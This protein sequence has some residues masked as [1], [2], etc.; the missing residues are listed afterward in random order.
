MKST[1][2]GNT[3]KACFLSR[4]FQQHLKPYLRVPQKWGTCCSLHI[5]PIPSHARSLKRQYPR[6]FPLFLWSISCQIFV[7][8][9]NTVESWALHLHQAFTAKQDGACLLRTHILGKIHSHHMRSTAQ[10]GQRRRQEIF[11]KQGNSFV[12]WDHESHWS[13][14]LDTRP[15]RSVEGTC[16]MDHLSDTQYALRRSQRASEQA[17][18][19]HFDV[20]EQWKL[21]RKRIKE[22]IWSWRDFPQC[23]MPLCAVN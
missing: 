8:V 19:D 1:F 17:K 15:W 10:C 18:E 20:R 14:L 6:R 12:V 21:K 16:E 9:W 11:T 2:L 23:K 5:P 4:Q 22:G 7:R 3:S 13:L